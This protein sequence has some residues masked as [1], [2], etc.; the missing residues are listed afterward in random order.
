MSQFSDAAPDDWVS[1][2]RS[3]TVDVDGTPIGLANVEGTFVAFTN[4]CPHQFTPLGGQPLIR[5]RFIRCPGHGSVFD[6]TTGQCVVPSQD[7]W[8]GT[9]PT[10]ETRVVDGIVQIRL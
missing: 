9:L 10:Y 6:V 5:G 2:G 8:T 7:G 1:P 4:D 3:T